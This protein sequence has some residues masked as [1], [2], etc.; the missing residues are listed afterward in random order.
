MSNARGILWHNELLKQEQRVE[1]DFIFQ[2]TVICQ[3]SG[4]VSRPLH[5][6]NQSSTR[7]L[8]TEANV[9]FSIKTLSSRA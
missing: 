1:E 6:V 2:C 3:M 8:Y 5:F 9:S 4:K 7:T